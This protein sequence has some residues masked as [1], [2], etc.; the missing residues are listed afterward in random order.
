MMDKTINR[1]EKA[2]DKFLDGYNCA[3]AVLYAFCDD[4][5]LD[6]EI[7]L[8]LLCGFGAGMGRKEEICGAV[9]GGIAVLS[10]RYGRGAKGDKIATKR[11]YA[12]TAELMDRFKE[13]QGTY[14]C[15]QLLGNYDL[16][17]VQ[18]VKY[19]EENDLR[20]KTCRQCVQTVTEILEDIM[21]SV[22]TDT[23]D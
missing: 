20:S 3:Q 9:S 6:P 23:V 10:M 2:V 19:F 7:A 17:T 16:N 8:K 13:R 21:C 12:K 15:R 1:T 4:L 5:N 18:G 11:T 22:A 14:I